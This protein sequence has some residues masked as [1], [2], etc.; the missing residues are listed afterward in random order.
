MKL[1]AVLS[2]PR[3]A[4][5]SFQL[6][7]AYEWCSAGWEKVAGGTFITTIPS[8]LERFSN[9]NPHV[10]YG[11]SVLRVAKQHP[12]LFGTLVEWGEVLVGIGLIASIVLYAMNRSVR[13]Q[14]LARSTAMLALVAGILMNLAFFFAAG[15]M[16]ASTR[17]LNLL[18]GGMQLILLLFWKGTARI[19]P[20]S[21]KSSL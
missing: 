12:S 10:W 19:P 16:S 1:S 11:D 20:H 14:Q 7:L 3:F 8:T 5:W 6:L 21:S 17:G 18:M 13:L 9:N 2:D 15:W 4:P